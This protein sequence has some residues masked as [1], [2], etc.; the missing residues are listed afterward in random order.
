MSATLPTPEQE[1]R[2]RWDLLLLDLE[3]R[4]EQI[5]QMKAFE[6]RRLAIQ[7]IGAT[8]A[9]FIAGA[10]VGALL[11]NTLSRPPTIAV[12]LDQPLKPPPP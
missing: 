3:H 9:V 12:H 10:A 11:L 4:A 1:Q 2:A 5:R 6:G 7:A 8:A